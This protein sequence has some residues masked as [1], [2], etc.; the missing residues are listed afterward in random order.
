MYAPCISDFWI[1][2]V[3]M[4]ICY[5]LCNDWSPSLLYVFITALMLF[6]DSSYLCLESYLLSCSFYNGHC[7]RKLN[8][9]T[10][11]SAV[12]NFTSTLELL[13]TDWNICQYPICFFKWPKLEQGIGIGSLQGFLD[14]SNLQPDLKTP[15]LASLSIQNT[16]EPHLVK[17]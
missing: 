9:F 13:K 12:F 8:F 7:L 14:E 4:R 5:H 16:H 17:T 3:M 1:L 2:L 11:S 10:S 15:I 6:L